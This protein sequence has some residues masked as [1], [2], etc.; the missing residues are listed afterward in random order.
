ML[1]HATAWLYH[2]KD[3]NVRGEEKERNVVKGKKESGNRT[4]DGP[5]LVIPSENNFSELVAVSVPQRQNYRYYQESSL[6]HICHAHHHRWDGVDRVEVVR[7]PR[8]S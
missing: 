7:K 8:L 6:K 3:D 1:G 5:P 4:A 2:E